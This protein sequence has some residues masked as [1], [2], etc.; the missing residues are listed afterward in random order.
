[1]RSCAVLMLCLG[2]GLTACS[3]DSPKADG[4]AA[5]KTKTAKKA[6]AKSGGLKAVQVAPGAHATCARMSD[7]GVRCWGRN[8]K[9]EHG[10]DPATIDAATPVAVPGVAGATALWAGGNPGDAGDLFCAQDKGGKV[11]CWGYHPIKPAGA[12]KRSSK[13]EVIASLAG[14]KSLSL[15]SG[16]YYALRGDSSLEAW[17]SGVFNS[18]G[19]GNSERRR[20]LGKLAHTPKAK[21]VTAG[22]NHGCALLDDGSVSC[23]GYSRHKKAPSPI[24]G[25]AKAT[26]IAAMAAG[27]DTCAVL[28]DKTVSCW[29]DYK[30]EPKPAEGLSGVV[31]IVARNSFCARTDKGEVYCWGRNYGGEVGNGQTRKAV[32]KPHKV[33][34]ITGAVDIG[35]GVNTSCAVLGDGSVK[36]WGWNTRGQLGDGS[37]L[38]RTAPVAVKGLQA[39]KLAPAKDGSDQVPESKTAMDWTGLPAAC[40][41]PSALEASNP[42]LKTDF[43]VVSAYAK[44]RGEGKTL[45][46]ALT[47]YAI[48]PGTHITPRGKQFGLNLRF[49]KVDMEKKEAHAVDVGD[50]VLGFK[51]P[52]KVVTTAYHKAGSGTLA[53]LSLAGASPG[54]VK[55]THLDDKW[56]CGEF[57]L[58]TKHSSFKGPYAA[59]LV[60]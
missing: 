46:I 57:A 59:R 26:A 41:K 8:D 25:L 28:A 12:G 39:P 48:D 30:F 52:R 43:K 24:P 35:A 51:E 3:K 14:I 49:A 17:G 5:G 40:T 9:G 20:P 56:V 15:G 53:K 45:T 37:L 4:K 47:N 32:H 6:K 60:K 2:F 13:P 36:C 21:A 44:T 22:Q 38:D 11:T 10:A 7:G 23:W 29:G 42:N 58:K 18:M 34:G 16:T 31:Q 33:P 1:M 19:D 54:T 27:S 55:I 50:Y